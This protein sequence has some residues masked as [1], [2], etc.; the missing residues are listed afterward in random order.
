MTIVEKRKVFSSIAFS[1]GWSTGFLRRKHLSLYISTKR[2][3][4]IPADYKD[5]I[6]SWLQF[7]RR[8]QARFD[9]ELSEIANIDQTPIAFKFLDR[10][11]YDTKGIKTVFVKQTGS[12]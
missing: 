12:G 1:N 3:Q 4:V 6:I 5:K 10:R 11:T 7:N 2:A 8:A 9:F